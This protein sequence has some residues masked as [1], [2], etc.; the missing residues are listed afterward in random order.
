MVGVTNLK[1]TQ[2]EYTLQVPR[3][4]HLDLSTR[5]GDIAVAGH[6][7]G[8]WN[9]ETALG[10]I[11]LA[12]GAQPDLKYRIQTT[13]GEVH[14]AAGGHTGHGYGELAGAIGS[15]AAVV[16]AVTRLGDVTIHT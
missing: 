11:T 10:D 8:N 4:V 14:V 5:A 1:D 6:P 7:A 12:V 15:G 9:L 3:G 2:V 13:L 16:Q